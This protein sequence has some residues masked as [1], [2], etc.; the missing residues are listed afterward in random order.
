M[1]QT[2]EWKHPMWMDE[3]IYIDFSLYKPSVPF[4]E[5]LIVSNKHDSSY[6]NTLNT[7]H[8][9]EMMR[10]LSLDI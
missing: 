7:K 9:W 2:Y 1:H 4:M 3:Q 8:S 5:R 6:P 10:D